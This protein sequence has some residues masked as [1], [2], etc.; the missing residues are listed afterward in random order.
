LKRR[1][2]L[3]AEDLKNLAKEGKEKEELV[4]FLEYL[5]KRGDELVT[6]VNALET[7]L[8]LFQEKNN[9]SSFRNYLA[10]VE[11]LISEI[12]RPD[13]EDLYRSMDILEQAAVTQ[14]TAMDCAVCLNRRIFI[15]GWHPGR[16]LPGMHVLRKNE[17]Q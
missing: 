17:I 6:S 8:I 12:I 16:D 5:L 2:F 13:I 9:I 15:S 10:S 14:E 11:S 1:L 4:S 7:V 3:S